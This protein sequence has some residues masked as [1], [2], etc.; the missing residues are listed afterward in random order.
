LGNMITFNCIDRKKLEGIL[1][2]IS[3]IK[4]AVIGDI[5][6]DVYWRADMTKS[7]LSRETPHF[8]LPVVEECMSPGAGGN[9]AANVVALNPSKAYIL[10]VVGDDWRGNVLVQELIKR[11]INTKGIIISDK[12]VTNAYCKPMRKGISNL[13]YE[14][15]RIDFANYDVL[16]SEVEEKLLRDL[17][18]V[19]AKIDVLCVTDQFVFGCVTKRVRERIM[20]LSRR[21]LMVVVDSRDRIALFRDVILKPNELEGYRAVYDNDAP[22]KNSFEARIKAAGIL[23][24]RNSSK[25]CMTLG[26][27]GCV[28]IDEGNVSYI[29]SYEVKPPIDTCGAGDTFLAAFSCALA[30]GAVGVEAVSFANMAANVTIKKHGMTGTASPEEIMARYDEIFGTGVCNT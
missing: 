26:E 22:G 30:A 13:E 16:P 24:E 27:K 23:A 10:S 15:P 28:Y 18:Q 3:N 9:T 5:S 20:E 7:E 25:V 11:G 4:V 14:D 12:V 21:G 1:K 17:E 19:S 8:N 29:P 6:L 2:G